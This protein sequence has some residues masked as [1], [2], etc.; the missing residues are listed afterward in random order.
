MSLRARQEHSSEGDK[1]WTCYGVASD[2]SRAF[3][4]FVAPSTLHP[5]SHLSLNYGTFVEDAD[6][7]TEPG[8]DGCF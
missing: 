7:D 6:L 8:G 3:N 4:P 1:P 2:R 5:M